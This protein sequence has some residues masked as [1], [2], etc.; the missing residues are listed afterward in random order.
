[1]REPLFLL[2]LLVAVAF[3]AAGS[4]YLTSAR[5]VINSRG[6]GAW[7]AGVAVTVALF[8]ALWLLFDAVNHL[9]QVPGTYPLVIGAVLLGTALGPQL[10]P[11][12]A[13]DTTARV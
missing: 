10:R 6:R 13:R 9:D 5:A 2:E 11:R 1:M 8:V 12:V 7:A 3:G 4:V